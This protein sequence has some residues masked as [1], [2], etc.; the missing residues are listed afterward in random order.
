MKKNLLLFMASFLFLFSNGIEV[1]AQ[2]HGNQVT[3][4]VMS[5]NIYHGV[6]L[7]GEL[8]LERTA[9]VI[10]DADAEIVGIQEVDRYYGERSDFKDV[11]K[12]LAE[13]LGYHY[14]FAAN[15]N[16]GPADG[17]SQNRQYGTAILSE[18]PIIDSENVFLS[19]F[20][21]EQRGLL[22]TKINVRG[23]HLNVYNTHLGLD[24]ISRLAQVGE[25]IDVT[26]QYQGSSFL[27]G[28][29][30]AEPDSEEIQMLLNETYFEDAFSNID[31]ANTFP[32][33]NP[34][35]RIDY[36]LTSPDI[37]TINQRVIQTEAS[38]HLPITTEA[39][40]PK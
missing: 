15:L 33:I 1:S 2:S 37:E 38:D 16:L 36:I 28:D 26:S 17:Q 25:I 18:Y 24:V 20:G 19:S 21:R 11:A 22:R 14:V 6:G 40:I 8:N 10:K 9:D 35:K 4:D 32:V 12:E 31:N 27:M 29:L 23:I 34:I 30:N 13:L 5:Y 39:V 3:L 7:D